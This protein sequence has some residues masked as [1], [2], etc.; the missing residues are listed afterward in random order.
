MTE[1]E[2]YLL[3]RMTE[4]EYLHFDRM[5]EHEYLYLD[6][7]T[8]HEYLHLD[9]MT[10]HEECNESSREN[11]LRCKY[12]VHLKTRCSVSNNYKYL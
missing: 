4:H 10:E 11:K 12:P 1:H 2:Y 9:R 7:M 3:D 8:E 6:R 5:P